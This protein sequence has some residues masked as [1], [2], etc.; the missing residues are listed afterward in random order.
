M[1]GKIPG[2]V[3]R[4]GGFSMGWSINQDIL[5]IPEVRE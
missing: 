3:F 1:V 4:H 2:F 5:R